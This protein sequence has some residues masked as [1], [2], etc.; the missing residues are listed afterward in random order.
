VKK[1]KELTLFGNKE[2]FTIQYTINIKFLTTNDIINCTKEI[3]LDNVQMKTIVL[4]K[5]KPKIKILL[6][7]LKTLKQILTINLQQLMMN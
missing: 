4:L 6:P 5:K 3:I 1:E 2:I 7:Y